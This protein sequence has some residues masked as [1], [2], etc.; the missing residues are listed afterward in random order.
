MKKIVL[1]LAVVL[2]SLCASAQYTMVSNI[3]FPTEDESWGGN[4]FTSSMG[5]GY[6]LNDNYM[7]GA[8][9]SGD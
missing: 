5:I 9:K 4:S 7:I 1:M 2:T 8:R 3:D 6:A